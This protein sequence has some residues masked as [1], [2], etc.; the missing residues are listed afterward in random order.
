MRARMFFGCLPDGYFPMGGGGVTPKYALTAPKT[1]V[2]ERSRGVAA[3]RGMGAA[4]GRSRSVPSIDG[5]ILSVA[6]V[7]IILC[8]LQYSLGMV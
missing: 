2:A 7:F 3:E 5:V 8:I 1:A 4:A 6:G